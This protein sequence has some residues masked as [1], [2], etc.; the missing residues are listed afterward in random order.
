ILHHAS[1]ELS[2]SIDAQRY[3]APA[4]VGQMV[5]QGHLGLKT[6]SGFY[7]YAGQDAGAYRRD[8]LGRVLERLRQDGLWRAPQ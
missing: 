6:G 1:R 5:A 4:I 7:D 2:Q 8:V 3:A